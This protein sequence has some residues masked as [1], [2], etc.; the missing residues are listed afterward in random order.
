MTL[1]ISRDCG[2]NVNSSS[3]CASATASGH[4]TTCR[5]R[6]NAFRRKMSPMFWPQMIDQL[7]ADFF[8]DALQPGRTHLAR[9]TDREPIPGDDERLAAVHAA[10]KVRHQVAERAALPAL[11]EGLETL[12]DAVGGRRDLIGVDGVELLGAGRRLGIP[13]DQRAA[14]NHRPRTGVGGR[15]GGAVFRQPI[16]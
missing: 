3:S 10:A 1:T 9:R 7:A 14:A 2:S 15:H 12:R 6:L 5:P 16:C 13:E 8:G 11:V 4:C